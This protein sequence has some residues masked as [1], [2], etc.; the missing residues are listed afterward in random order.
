[1]RKV[2]ADAIRISPTRV[3]VMPAGS[4]YGVGAAIG[5]EPHQRLQERR[6]ELRGQRDQADLA[7]V[8]VVGLLE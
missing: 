5:V 3:K 8:Q 1:M 7:E 6:G 2:G 4:E